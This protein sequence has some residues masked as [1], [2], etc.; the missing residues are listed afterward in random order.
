MPL[1]NT[2]GEEIDERVQKLPHEQLRVREDTRRLAGLRSG[3][4]VL[5]ATEEHDDMEGQV[6]VRRDHL[7]V[8]A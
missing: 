4:S 3:C 8:H 2:P 7:V 5:A 6:V 1:Q